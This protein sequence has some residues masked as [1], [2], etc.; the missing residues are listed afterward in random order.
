MQI[1]AS[2]LKRPEVREADSCWS[3]FTELW[4]EADDVERDALMQGTV[5]RV[6]IDENE[7]GTCEIAVISQVPSD[8]LELTPKMGAGVGLEPT[9]FGL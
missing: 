8:G 7:E 6:D 3:H 4:K 5:K 2:R 1:E 9:T